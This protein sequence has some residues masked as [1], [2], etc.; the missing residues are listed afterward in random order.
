MA[1]RDFNLRAAA[2]LDRHLDQIVSGSDEPASEIEPSITQTVARLQHAANAGL[3]AGQR[4]PTMR[5]GR[6]RA[7]SRSFGPSLLTKPISALTTGVVAAL[8]VVGLIVSIAPHSLTTTSAQDEWLYSN[9]YTA[10]RLRE[11]DPTTLEPIG[12]AVRA[13][14]PTAV[15]TQTRLQRFWVL[16]V[17]GGTLIEVERRQQDMGVFPIVIR[18]FDTRTG[19]QRS[20]ITTAVDGSPQISADG[21]FLVIDPIA[22]YST[23]GSTDGEEVD[24]IDWLVYDTTTGDHVT[25]IRTP[26]R[27]P[28]IGLQGTLSP[29]GRH[30]WFLS[31]PAQPDVPGPW[32][33]TLIEFELAT[34]AETRRLELPDVLAGA[35]QT[36]KEHKLPADCF[37]GGIGELMP[38]TPELDV[39]S[40]A[41]AIAPSGR[42]IAVAHAD[43][44]A[45][46]LID[47]ATFLVLDTIDYSRAAIPA[48]PFVSPCDHSSERT[49]WATFSRDETALYVSG[50]DRHMRDGDAGDIT[51]LGVT[52]V[53]L[54]DGD[55]VTVGNPPSPDTYLMREL[56]VTEGGLVVFTL[57]NSVWTPGETSSQTA[58]LD[59]YEL[60]SLNLKLTNSQSPLETVGLIVSPV[61]LSPLTYMAAPEA[62]MDGASTVIVGA[63]VGDVAHVTIVADGQ[64]VFDGPL[65]RGDITQPISG[66]HIVVTSSHPDYTTINQDGES[67]GAMLE[68]TQEYR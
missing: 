2:Q 62:A 66:D 34:G 20:R 64:T 43:S 41:F 7:E 51:D 6:T 65:F 31:V 23:G 28:A 29:D 57:V 35:W 54:Q 26:E 59:Y 50:I 61:E 42:T 1:L 63:I 15:G 24:S 27:S 55:A 9:N 40:P 30:L 10:N 11:L 13:Y 38:A 8:L 14:D 53:S 45:I 37:A 5:L 67:Q 33:T 60:D 4:V 44:D 52:R 16:S 21:R 36:G 22:G 46:T 12:A 68:A 47:A 18:V 48:A 32:P 49:L 25:D 17:D 3:N 56:T 58:T 39:L 19:V